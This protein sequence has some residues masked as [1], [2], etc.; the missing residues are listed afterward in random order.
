[1]RGAADVVVEGCHLDRCGGNGFLLSGWA[2]N[3]TIR[4]NR[5]SFPGESGVVALG[6]SELIDGTAGTFPEKNAVE[7]NWI[8][9]IGVLGKEVSCY[10]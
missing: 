1:M 8:H 10:F 9:D 2:K 5:I 7:N 6:V 3:N 4:G